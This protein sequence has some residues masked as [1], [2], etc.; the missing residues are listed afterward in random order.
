MKEWWKSKTIWLNTI[1]I[2][3]ATGFEILAQF[4]NDVRSIAGEY[5]PYVVIVI[6]MLNQMLR[7]ITTKGIK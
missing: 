5:A 2:A 3:V 1:L 6:A 7:F 4:E